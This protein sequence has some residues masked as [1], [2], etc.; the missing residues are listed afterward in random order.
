MIDWGSVVANSLWISGCALALALIS[1]ASWQASVSG[2]ALRRRLGLRPYRLGFAAAGLLFCLGLGA[3]T[4]SW[5]EIVIWLV[6]AVVFAV[7]L[8]RAA[9]RA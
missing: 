3:T 8:A 5:V 7:Q 9:R 1:Y 6:L 4:H 2:G